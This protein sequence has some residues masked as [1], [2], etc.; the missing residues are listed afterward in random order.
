M[1]TPLEIFHS[2]YIINTWQQFVLI[3]IIGN[4]F[5][6]K[7]STGNKR[8]QYWHIFPIISVSNSLKTNSKSGLTR[9]G[10]NFILSAEDTFFKG[11]TFAFTSM[12][13]AAFCIWNC[14]FESATF[15]S[16]R[17]L[18]SKRSFS[19]SASYTNTHTLWWK[20]WIFDKPISV[21][22]CETFLT[23]YVVIPN[24]G[25]R[26]CNTSTE[27]LFSATTKTFNLYRTKTNI[28]LT[29]LNRSLL[30]EYRKN[31]VHIY[32]YCFWNNHDNL[33]KYIVLH[34][35]TIHVTAFKKNKK[36]RSFIPS[37]RPWSTCQ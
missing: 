4:L 13:K 10:S 31:Y 21:S 20:T 2:V 18:A 3:F 8:V 12:S 1:Q 34:I 35:C 15:V 26:T 11:L 16:A 14:L 28:F 22:N 6:I 9:L 23:E 37:L 32:I 29:E 24:N 17:Y 7:A 5:F 33:F 27:V 30:C 19:H 25:T 36:N